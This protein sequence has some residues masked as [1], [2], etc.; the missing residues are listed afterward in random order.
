MIIN[1]KPSRWWQ[2]S[3]GV[4]LLITLSLVGL[5]SAESTMTQRNTAPTSV[6]TPPAQVEKAK[7]AKNDQELIEFLGNTYFFDSNPFN[8]EGLSSKDLIRA[9]QERPKDRDILYMKRLA[10]MRNALVAEDFDEAERRIK[11]L[12]DMNDGSPNWDEQFARNINRELSEFIAPGKLHWVPSPNLDPEKYLRVA[13]LMIQKNDDYALNLPI[14][15]AA[16]IYVV[17]GE[18]D[19]AVELY[20]KSFPDRPIFF[21]IF[22]S[23]ELEY[24]H[25]QNLDLFQKRYKDLFAK[26]I[27]YRNNLQITDSQNV[28]FQM[29]SYEIPVQAMVD[30]CFQRDLNDLG[31]EILDSFFSPE[32]ACSI[33]AEFMTNYF[34]RENFVKSRAFAGEVLKRRNI[35]AKE[36][37]SSSYFWVPYTVY[38]ISEPL[39]QGK[40]CDDAVRKLSVQMSQI[41][42]DENYN[43]AQQNQLGGNAGLS[44]K[45]LCLIGILGQTFRYFAFADP[46]VL[47]EHIKR[48][49][50]KLSDTTILAVLLVEIGN[51]K[52]EG[53]QSYFSSYRS[54]SA[55]F[56]MEP[57]FPMPQSSEMGIIKMQEAFD[58]RVKSPAEA[59]TS[60]EIRDMF[61]DVP[62]YFQSVE[63]TV[64]NSEF[65]WSYNRFLTGYQVFSTPEEMKIILDQCV[66]SSGFMNES[67]RFSFWQN[68]LIPFYLGN[69]FDAE[70]MQLIRQITDGTYRGRALCDY[71]KA[72]CSNKRENNEFL[73]DYETLSA[74]QVESFRP[75]A[76]LVVDCACELKDSQQRFDAL[77]ALPQTG[78]D[79]LNFL[80]SPEIEK[81]VPKTA[82]STYTY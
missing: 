57:Y 68:T 32:Y 64:F 48:F 30:N 67:S 59:M 23:I 81:R 26:I 12:N 72:Q 55:S 27:E 33:L 22:Q 74:E 35:P 29:D 44:Q 14:Q 42:V 70:A 76:K 28:T 11:E 80:L 15:F 13:S 52:R 60:E 6:D 25:T 45:D 8:R 20:E 7:L 39:S 17:R 61:K 3:L 49:E 5:T 50:D 37:L 63:G 46:A 16:D 62:R 9:I 43:E 24:N 34:E 40:K 47:R 21:M 4:T 66:K 53:A 18:F 54:G 1:R 73:H 75:V 2:T 19:K 31:Y 71:F 41:V 77:Q 65:Y 69:R 58:R 10:Y 36:R 82:P 51:M 79:K 38:T 78:N 56:Q